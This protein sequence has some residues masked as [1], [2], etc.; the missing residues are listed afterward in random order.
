[1]FIKY[2]EKSFINPVARSGLVNLIRFAF[3]NI[4]LIG[5]NSVNDVDS[6]GVIIAEE[7]IADSHSKLA[8]YRNIFLLITEC[9]VENA[10]TGRIT[11]NLR[12][13]DIVGLLAHIL[14]YYLHLVMHLR[15]IGRFTKWDIIL[16]PLLVPYSAM[17]LYARFRGVRTNLRSLVEHEYMLAGLQFNFNKVLPTVSGLIF[18]HPSIFKSF[19]KYYPTAETFKV[20]PYPVFDDDFQF[21]ITGRQFLQINWYGYRNNWRE[22]RAKEVV[23]QIKAS[24]GKMTADINIEY[25]F[26]SVDSPE[27]F[28]LVMRQSETWPLSSSTKIRDILVAG[29]IPI[30]EHLFYDHPVC[31]LALH[32]NDVVDLYRSMEDGVETIQ[33]LEN[34]FRERIKSYN[35]WATAENL[36]NEDELMGYINSQFCTT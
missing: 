30:I 7:Y 5:I 1:M 29:K 22:R 34:D 27:I 31:G 21:N 26:T 36:K 9:F 13:G 4:K 35:A 17:Y 18:S 14:A 24:L 23:D 19:V 33:D 2:L 10:Y 12:G 16:L 32:L 20:I 15:V 25:N 3:P 28:H 11:R 6:A 8:G